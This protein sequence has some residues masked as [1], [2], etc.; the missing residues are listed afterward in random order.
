MN[1]TKKQLQTLR[2][3]LRSQIEWGAGGC[4]GDGDKITEKKDFA[5]A[6]ILLSKIDKELE[7]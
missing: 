6:K 1:L 2:Y 3:I 7:K 4:F 5:T